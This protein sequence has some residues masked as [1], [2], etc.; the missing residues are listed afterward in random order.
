MIETVEGFERRLNCLD[1]DDHA[2]VVQADELV[3]DLV[4]SISDKV[5]VAILRFFERYPNADCGAPGTLVHHMEGFYPNYVDA[6][7]DSVNRRPSF[8]GAL[9]VNRILNTDIDAKLRSRILAAL[10]VIIT[11]DE[12]VAAHVLKMVRGFIK[13]HS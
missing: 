2:F 1:P 6:L 3:S 4:P 8:N 12:Q 7:I 5:Y 10:N 11:S 9:I 13:R